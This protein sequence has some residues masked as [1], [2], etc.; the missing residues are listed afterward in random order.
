[1]IFI[2]SGALIA[3][4]VERDQYCIQSLAVWRDLQ[5]KRRRCLTSNFVLSEAFT[6]LARRTTYQFAANRAR[7]LY[8]SKILE[9]LR[10]SEEDELA[11]LQYFEKYA[12]QNVSFTDCVSF[13]LMKRHGIRDVFTFDRHFTLAGFNSRP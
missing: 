4:F 8:S 9:I 13:A 5:E 3:R 7:G 12:D 2:D 11:A 10:P 1:V 6:L